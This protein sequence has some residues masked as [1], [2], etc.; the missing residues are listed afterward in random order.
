MN[1]IEPNYFKLSEWSKESADWVK[2]EWQWIALEAETRLK[3]PYLYPRF[4]VPQPNDEKV[5]RLEP[6]PTEDENK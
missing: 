2:A 4:C 5:L 1:N 6:K 3:T